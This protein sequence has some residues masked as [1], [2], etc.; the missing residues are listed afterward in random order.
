[1]TVT[2]APTRLADMIGDTPWASPVYADLAARV[3]RLIVDG[4]LSH[5]D[6]LPG[7]RALAERLGLSRTTVTTAYERLRETGLLTSLRGSGSTVNLPFGHA[8]GSALVEAPDGM[9]SMTHA[10]PPAP[11][12]LGAAY[13]RALSAMPSVLTT[14]G[15]LPDGLPALTER[16]AAR[17]TAQG[18]PTD[19]DQ[20]L[21]TSG[22]QSALAVAAR[23]AL[24]RGDRVLVEAFVYPHLL[25]V[26]RGAGARVSA[27]PHGDSP[28][29]ADAVE[30]RLAGAEHRAAFL[31][32]DFH[33]PTGE[34][35]D[36]PG[37]ERLAELLRRHA[38]QPV[39][40]ETLRDVVLDDGP[41]P[42]SY[43]RYDE[44]TVLVGSAAKSVW[45]GLRVGWIR[46]PRGVRSE[47]VHARM[48]HDL[49]AAPFEQ[50]VLAEVIDAGDEVFAA[51][52]SVLGRNRDALRLALDELMPALEVPRPRGGLNLWSRLPS[53]DST[54]FCAAAAAHGVGLVPG[55]R[56]AAA[57]GQRSERYVRLPYGQSPEVLRDAVSRLAA[58]WDDLAASGAGRADRTAELLV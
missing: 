53:P 15:Y 36:A 8:V 44:R 48:A 40:D 7:E 57:G 33:N 17:L 20:V 37:R 5:G 30:A 25:D 52:R 13:E 16:L 32:P 11:A 46:A 4:R 54:R 56:F 14:A 3:R 34:L 41:V 42:P 39:I 2:V 50:L 22:A 12:G 58:A 55:P 24:G 1:M 26:L 6:R 49:G 9:I 38:V 10:A 27:I 21:V 35:L 31:T 29:D 47:L 43:A 51:S 45:G 18:L 19:P 23:W 28:W